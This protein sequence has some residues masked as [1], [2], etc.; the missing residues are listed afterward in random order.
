MGS[1]KLLFGVALGCFHA[2][3]ALEIVPPE[4]KGCYSDLGSLKKLNESAFQSSGLCQTVCVKDYVNQGQAGFSVQA[5]TNGT[6]CL[7][8]N[9]LPNSAFMVDKDKCG[10]SCPGYPTD[11]CGQR[12]GN[13]V[14][15]YIS[16]IDKES[17]IP[18]EPKP[19]SSVTSTLPTS[20]S[21][22]QA[23]TQTSHT[24]TT[25][26]AQPSPTS[27][28]TPAINKAG[29]AAGIVVGVLF[30]FA[31]GLGVWFFLRS[32]RRK[33]I[34]EEY[35]KSAAVR[36]FAQKPLSDHRLD[37]GMVQKRDSVGSIADNQ[38]YSRRILKV[39]NPDC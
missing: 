9:S 24:N 16:G 11:S 29:V 35:R 33:Q 5:M 7:C 37:P 36:G 26:S 1:L 20:T 4:F 38:D 19:T 15:V 22:S 28:P 18:Q 8:G 3:T 25:S 21:T 34:E 12:L 39:T 2:I 32:R 10:F 13:F 6:A 31:T 14:S 17:N 30:A 23:P 27:A